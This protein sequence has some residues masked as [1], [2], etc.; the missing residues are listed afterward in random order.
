MVGMP[1]EN[2]PLQ[3]IALTTQALPNP[4]GLGHSTPVLRWKIRSN[5]P[6][7]QTV[8]FELQAAASESDL[9]AETSLLWS[10]GWLEE[11]RV[12]SI[13][14]A[15]APLTSRARCHW[16]VRVRDAENRV[17]SWS[18]PAMFELGLLQAT[19]WQAQWMACPI[20]GGPRN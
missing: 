13:T 4:V 17:S 11:P 19:D 6:G 16:R 3:P 1:E 5:E 9:L 20:Q 7:Q 18:A 8:A 12:Q 10:T 14:Y 15:G 2:S